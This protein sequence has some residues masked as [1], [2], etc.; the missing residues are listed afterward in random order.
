MLAGQARQQIKELVWMKA[1]EN[2]MMEALSRLAGLHRPLE[3]LL[4]D[5]P[6]GDGAAGA[7]AAVP[8]QGIQSLP[9]LLESPS[10]AAAAEA[11]ASPRPSGP[12]AASRCD[13]PPRRPLPRAHGRKPQVKP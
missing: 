2:M 6:P 10:R 12:D 4:R 11:A 1:S 13:A 7:A 3:E 9:E 8:P 5:A